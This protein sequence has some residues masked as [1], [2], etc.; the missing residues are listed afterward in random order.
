MCYHIRYESNSFFL[1]AIPV[2][3]KNKDICI[4]T[5]ALLDADSDTSLISLGIVNKLNVDSIKLNMRI[6]NEVLNE[7]PKD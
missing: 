6:Q 4:E 5:S 2:V 3:L 7:K 1:Q